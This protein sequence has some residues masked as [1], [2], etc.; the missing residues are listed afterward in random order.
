MGMDSPARAGR[1]SGRGQGAP[2][3]TAVEGPPAAGGRWTPKP[4][5]LPSGRRLPLPGE[6]E[7]HKN[8]R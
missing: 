7:Q 5:L 3:Y 6:C 4:T 2:P 1:E 8:A